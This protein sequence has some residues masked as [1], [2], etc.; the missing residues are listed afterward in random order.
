[1]L[2]RGNIIFLIL[3]NIIGNVSI[4]GKRLSDQVV[5]KHGAQTINGH[6][7]ITAPL[8]LQENFI[9]NGT[10]DGVDLK[11][12]YR[13]AIRKN[14]NEPIRGT[15]WFQAGVNITERLNA[16]NVN[17]IDLNTLRE[18]LIWINKPATWQSAFN[19]EHLSVNQLTIDGTI[20]NYRIPEDFVPLNTSGMYVRTKVFLRGS[21]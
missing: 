20:N 4:D 5:T 14:S 16:E 1:M 15:K 7:T 11:A 3:G 13:D 2:R 21:H 9:T 8:T 6:K 17:G 18:N 10:I 19:F 12:W